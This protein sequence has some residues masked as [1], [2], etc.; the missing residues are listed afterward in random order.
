MHI[1][2]KLISMA[3]LQEYKDRIFA[4]HPE[5]IHQSIAADVDTLTA[6]IEV[7]NVSLNELKALQDELNPQPEVPG[8][9][10]GQQ[11]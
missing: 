11:A 4:A 5:L 7:L 6:Q 3:T 1:I 8:V 2:S 9:H 10:D